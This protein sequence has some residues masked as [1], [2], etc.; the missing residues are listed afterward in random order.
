I[1]PLLHRLSLQS[2]LNR[3]DVVFFEWV[4]ENL[5]LASQLPHRAKIIARLHSWE[6]FHHAKRV[7]W[8]AVDRLVLVSQAK[9]RQFNERFPGNEEKIMALPAGKSLDHFSPKPHSFSGKIAMLGHII[10]VKRV[11]EMVLTLAELHKRGFIFTLHLGGEPKEGYNNQRYYASV[12]SLVEKLGLRKHV[13]F[14]GYVDSAQ[15]LPEMDI[16]ISNSYWE[17]QQ[18]ALI[19]AMAAGCYSLSHVWDGAEEILPEENLFTTETSLVEKILS[20]AALSEGEKEERQNQMRAIAIEKYGL[21]DFIDRYH[22]LIES[23]I[24]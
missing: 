3:Q 14:D 24:R 9:Q 23:V 5:V 17:G 7:N 19:E 12:L 6:L 20:Y 15:W 13:F 8:Q 16:F 10:D 21:Q 2:F 11:Y 4:G 18:N 22:A 1:N